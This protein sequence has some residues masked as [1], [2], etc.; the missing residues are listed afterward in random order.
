MTAQQDHPLDLDDLKAKLHHTF[1][2]PGAPVP[3]GEDPEVPLCQRPPV[4]DK[5]VFGIT[6]V[7][8]L[9]IL[10]WGLVWPTPF[11]STMTSI[12]NWVVSNMGWLLIA[13]A[14]CFVLFAGWLALIKY[15][16]IPLGLDGEKPEFN[17]VIW[18]AMM[19]SAVMCIVLIFWCVT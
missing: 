12:L 8:V 19:F 17:T 18:V 10:V 16:K 7:L 3:P 14:T 13:S 2:G 4:I 15:V 9:A 6:A 1:P 5:V 11:G